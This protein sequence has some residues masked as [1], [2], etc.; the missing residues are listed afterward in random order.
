VNHLE[1]SKTVVGMAVTAAAATATLSIDTLGYSYASIDVIVG[2]S[3]TAADTATS[4]LA[5][6]NLYQGVN[7]NATAA[8]YTVAVP[9]ASVKVTA[10]ASIIRMDIDL[11]GKRRY[12]KVDASPSINTSTI[13]VARLSKGHDNT[14]TASAKG[15]LEKY[16]G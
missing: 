6:L 2:R 16:S 8:V 12:L 10:Q 1:A 7:T 4:I 9:A 11:R 14:D 5:A 3:A 13:I 15:V